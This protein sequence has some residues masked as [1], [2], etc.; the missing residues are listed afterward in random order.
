M[1]LTLCCFALWEVR[2]DGHA[3]L[4]F[5]VATQETFQIRDMVGLKTAAELGCRDSA[6]HHEKQGRRQDFAQ[7]I[8]F[9]PFAWQWGLSVLFTPASP[10]PC[11]HTPLLQ[12]MTQAVYREGK[13]IETRQNSS[14]SGTALHTDKIILSSPR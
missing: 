10:P 6:A 3:P 14:L 12:Q 9:H 1:A 2:Q 13:L 5:F 7:H 8:H 11:A 4:Y